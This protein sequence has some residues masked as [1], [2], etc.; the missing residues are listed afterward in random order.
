MAMK[1]LKTAWNG[2]RS[3]VSMAGTMRRPGSYLLLFRLENTELLARVLDEAGHAHVFSRISARL[4]KALQSGRIRPAPPG[5]FAV[6]LTDVTKARAMATARHAQLQGERMLA[7][8]GQMINPVL[9][10]LVMPNLPLHPMTEAELIA[11]GCRIVEQTDSNLL[12]QITYAT[13]ENGSLPASAS[14]TENVEQITLF[15]PITCCYSG[16]T[17]GFELHGGRRRQATDTDALISNL[18]AA[19]DRDCEIPLLSALHEA[20]KALRF[21]DKADADIPRISI[22]VPDAELQMPGFSARVIDELMRMKLPPVRLV[23]RIGNA[24]MSGRPSVSLRTN[25]RNLREIGCRIELDGFGIGNNGLDKIRQLAVN[26]VRIDRSFVFCCDM[27]P[28]QQRTIRAI[29]ALAEQLELCTTAEGVESPEEHAFL[30]RSG[31]REVQ[32]CAIAPPMPLEQTLDFLAQQAGKAMPLNV[33]D[34]M[35]S[36]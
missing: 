36:G 3:G 12:G 22:S 28:V 30:A 31:C 1:F 34:R 19:D 14:K 33:A 18:Q 5:F 2:L 27:E 26:S 24:E 8:P 7:V 17:V 23:L 11:Q 4:G 32:G 25:L 10:A 21:W 13:A 16:R 6:L 15:Q 9:S 20:R 35:K 29:L